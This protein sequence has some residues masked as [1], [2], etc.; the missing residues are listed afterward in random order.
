MKKRIGLFGG[1]FNPVHIGHLRAA[2]EIK[3]KLS[4]DRIVFVPA[5]IHPL[6]KISDLA[7]ADKRLQML[8]IAVSDNPAFQVSDIEL[9]REGPSYTIDTLKQ[10]SKKYGKNNMFFILGIENLKRIDEWKDYK[11]L[12]K[13]SNFAVIRRPGYKVGDYKSAFPKQLKN[14]FKRTDAAEDITIYQGRNRSK[15][16][17]LKISGIRISSSRVRNLLKNN[18]S[19]NYFIPPRLNSYIKKN[20]LYVGE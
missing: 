17:F 19:A 14:M 8:K 11:S 10:L 9:K 7:S 6:K 15:L 20:K 12:F 1:S 13:Y 16:I 18:K 3:E 5:R 2:E 4:L